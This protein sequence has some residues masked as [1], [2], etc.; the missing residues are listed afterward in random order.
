MTKQKNQPKVDA[1]AL[2]NQLSSKLCSVFL[3]PE[4][5]PESL[6]IVP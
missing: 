5:T 2:V 6:N 1:D 4:I 3:A